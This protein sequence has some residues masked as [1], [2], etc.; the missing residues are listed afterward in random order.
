M[1][2]PL[3]TRATVIGEIFVLFGEKR[4]LYKMGHILTIIPTRKMADKELFST[5]YRKCRNQETMNILVYIALYLY[6]D[7]SLLRMSDSI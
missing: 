6:W 2:K 5:S 7:M 3:R 4:R 1:F